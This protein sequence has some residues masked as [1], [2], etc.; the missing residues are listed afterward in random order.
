MRSIVKKQGRLI[1]NM[2]SYAVLQI[3]N[4]LVGLFLPRLYLAVYG[5]EVN[6][7]ISTANS[8]ISYFSYLEAG[9]GLTLIHS[10]FKP[11]AENNAEQTNG[12]L[13][14]SQKQYRRISGIYFAIV[15][16]L[17]LLFPII[18]SSDALSRW[19]FVSLVFVIG[20]YGALDFFTMA[21]YRVLLTA[22]R[23]EYVISNAFIIAQLL[24]FC[25]VWLLLQF[26]ISVVFVKIVPILTLLVRSLILRIY[27]KRN[28]PNVYYDAPPTRNLS[29]TNNR[30]DALLL[31][32]SINTSISL[33]TII[34]SQVLG[35]KEANVYAVYSMIASAMISIVSALSSG[36]SPQMGQKLSRGE[37]VTESYEIYD[38]I[39]SLIISIVF[40]TMAFMTIPFVK[41]YTSV[42][43]DVNY[44]YPVY[45]ILISVWA[46]LYSYR[47]PMTAVINAAGIYR[48]NR[49]SNIVNLVLQIVAG[50]VGAIFGGIGGVLVVMILAS[51]QRN[52]WFAF[53]NSKC[54]LHNG[55]KSAIV[56]QC[57]IVLLILANG[58]LAKKIT[59]GFEITILLW[60]VIAIAVFMAEVLI[61]STAF[62]AVDHRSAKLVL[63]RLKLRA[64]FNKSKN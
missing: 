38:F 37:S 33:P 22:D 23:K 26:N 47:I 6:G 28:Y 4:M 3:V 24:R 57:L 56:Y 12:I 7:I 51:I 29:V 2:T 52:I 13:S 50:I 62:V 20:V 46:A 32:I 36:V 18:S 8:F 30:W 44:I 16:A 39:V 54:L 59:S 35:F 58:W 11:L 42:V 25:F 64:P 45:A 17:S 60:V 49:I 15:V 55:V 5:S 43:D 61:C 31:Q 34:I 27:I 41:L 63:R 21:K 14:Y 19:E 1:T 9:I 40:S 48:G 10:L 53:V